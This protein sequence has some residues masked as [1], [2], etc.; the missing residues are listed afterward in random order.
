MTHV[1]GVM[2]PPKGSKTSDGFELQWG[3][4]GMKPTLT[5]I[6]DRS[7]WTLRLH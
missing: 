4:N 2:C 7:T 6:V 5:D 1:R 3:T